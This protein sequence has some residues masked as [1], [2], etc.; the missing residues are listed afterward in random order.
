MGIFNADCNDLTI[1]VI[2][3]NSI[4]VALACIWAEKATTISGSGKLNL[5]SNVQDGIH[6]QQAPVTIEN[7]S[8]YA[9]GTY[10]IKGGKRKRSGGYSAQ[11]SRG[12]LREKRLSVSN[13]WTRA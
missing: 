7:C 10:G 5:K 3:E 9:E 11:C 1:N 13:L 6:L 2:G 8:V 12:G 4:S